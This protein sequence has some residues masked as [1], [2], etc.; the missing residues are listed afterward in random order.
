MQAPLHSLPAAR[1]HGASRL[2]FAVT[3]VIIGLLAWVLLGRLDELSRA[4]RRERLLATMTSVKAVATIFH[5]RCVVVRANAD[6]GCDHLLMR[7]EPMDGVQGWPAAS[8][9][10]IARAVTALAQ[11]A[12]APMPGGELRLQSATVRGRPAL[13]IALGDPRCE[14]FYAQA[15]SPG[16]SPEVDIVDVSC[17]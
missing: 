13:L 6:A 15:M 5:E 8:A 9:G 2:E 17:P 7:G 10:G 12:S 16:D 14:F 11:A 3:L 4:A 1:S